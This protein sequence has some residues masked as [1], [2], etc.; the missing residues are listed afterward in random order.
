MTTTALRSPRALIRHAGAPRN[1]LIGFLVTLGVGIAL[2]AGTATAIGITSAGRVL[3]GVTVGGVEI[4]GLDRAAAIEL[5]S[6]RLP[7]L[8]SGHASVTID[9]ATTVVAY[10]TLGRSYE[11]EQMV[12][13]AMAVGRD[14]DPLTVSGERFRSLLG[15]TA[16]PVVVHPYDLGAMQDVSVQLA[17]R[18][19][20]A[21]VDARVSLLNGSYAVS[22]AIAGT[23][24]DPRAISSA[25]AAV[26]A[27]SDPADASIALSTTT[28]PATVSTETAAAAA[29]AA[30]GITAA[31]LELTLGDDEEA[32]SFTVEQL[33][34]LLTFATHGTGYDVVVDRAGADALVVSLAEAVDRD[35]VSARFAYGAGGPSG[36]IAGVIGRELD[37]EG[38]VAAV[39]DALAGRAAGASIPSL[40]I[41]TSQTA[42]ALTTDVAQ[43]ALGKMQRISSWTTKYVPGISNFYGANISIPAWDIDGRTLAPGEWFSFWNSIGPVTTARGYGEGGAIIN[44]RS[45]PT[46]ALAGGICSTSTTIFNAA[47]RAG[48]NMG[49][50]QNHYYYISRYPLGL[51]ATVF[52]T[53]SYAI[54]MTFQND[55]SSPILIRSYAAAGYVR[56]DLWGVPTGRTVSFSQPVVSNR[57]AASDVTVIDTTLA[58][59]TAVRDETAHDGMD[60]SVTRWVY[61]GGGTLIHRETYFSPYKAVT[62]IT[63]VGPAPAPP[64]P[65]DPPPPDDPPTT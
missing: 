13:A 16:L 21:P 63:R 9:G 22:P 2:L 38:T 12:D 5:V 35:P 3:P 48:L 11:T 6:S 23:R 7:S 27:T 14:G 15:P 26:V 53:D 55:T 49:E 59:G 62:G 47:L 57:R 4:G 24:L 64:P 44:G 8:S 56:F 60:V 41:V 19:A 51:D 40:A 58:P 32:L 39:R 18:F 30:N 25:L 61:D 52:R 31:P 33:R 10:G 45:Q 37:V 34:G 46:G 43:S 36:V 1:A 54:D 65:E 28:R 29:A 20:H 50:R 42:P 17:L